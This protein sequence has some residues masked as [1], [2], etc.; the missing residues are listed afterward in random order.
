MELI[1]IK[2]I[3][4][5]R[6]KAFEDAEILSCEDLINYFPYKYY[7]FSKTEPFADDGNIRLIKALVVEN[8]KIVKARTNLSFVTCKVHDE[9]GHTFNAVWFNQTFIK[10]VL[11]LGQTVF[12]YGK[13]SQKKKKTFNVILM[14]PEEKLEKFGLLPVYHS[15]SGIGQST[16]SETINKSLNMLN[17]SSIIP[18][19][20]L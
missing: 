13:N 5:T 9:L 19:N 15:I 17:L 12:L 14:R 7:D 4:K 1:N 3:G 6:Q 8:P 20:I 16:I 11:Y 2:G 10:S 18:D